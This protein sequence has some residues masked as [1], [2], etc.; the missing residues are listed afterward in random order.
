MV[1][2]LAPV[3]GDAP[4][5][6]TVRRAP[7]LARMPAMRDRIARALDLAVRPDWPWKDAFLTCWQRLCA[8]P[9]PA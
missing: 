4:G 8:L 5:G 9:A 3:L 7:D 2:H 1:A 6:P